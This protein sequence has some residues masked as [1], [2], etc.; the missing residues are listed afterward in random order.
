[1]LAAAPKQAMVWGFC[2]SDTETVTVTFGGQRLKAEV[3]YR[4]VGVVTWSVTLPATPAGFTPHTIT[5]ASSSGAT[6]V[7]EDVLFGSVFV[8]SGQ[9]NM[10]YG[11]NGTN[12]GCH[13]PAL[14][15][16]LYIALFVAL[17]SS[18]GFFFDDL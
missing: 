8:A 6:V 5:A 2:N 16:S 10:A 9:S 11:L 7:I 18:N 12:G 17:R 1:M 3:G 4:T 15:R 14:A 13:V